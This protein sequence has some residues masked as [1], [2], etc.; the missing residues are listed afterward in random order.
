MVSKPALEFTSFEV[1]IETK[2]TFLNL[3]KSGTRL[4][5]TESL[6]TKCVH[7]TLLELVDGEVDR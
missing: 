5:M 7:T 2:A 4:S 6:P 1:L 3:F